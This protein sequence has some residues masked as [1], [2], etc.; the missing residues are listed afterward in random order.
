MSYH[1][2]TDRAIRPESV[3]SLS[4]ASLAR[5]FV[6]AEAKFF[7]QMTINE[8]PA[9]A[10]D[11]DGE[12][13]GCDIPANVSALEQAETLYEAVLAERDRRLL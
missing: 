13:Y 3:A 6:F 11:E 1:F 5:V 10:L 12:V 2:K 9:Y 4:A 8:T 7:R